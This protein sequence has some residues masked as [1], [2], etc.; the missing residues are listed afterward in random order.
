MI[1]A[2]A[3]LLV[4]ISFFYLFVCVNE[5]GDGFLARSKVLVTKKFPDKLRE[6]AA[7]IC[8]QR[9]VNLIDRTAHYICFEPN[10][11]V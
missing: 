7:K 6:I 2:Y 9:F 11:L 3:F 8:G 5:H 4:T 10:P 1:W